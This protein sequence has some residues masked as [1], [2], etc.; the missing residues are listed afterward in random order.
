M[1]TLD[2]SPDMQS[3][4]NRC[5]LVTWF[6]RQLKEEKVVLDGPKVSF[7]TESWGRSH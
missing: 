3:E 1:E 6:D 2:T 7:A 5:K 4:R